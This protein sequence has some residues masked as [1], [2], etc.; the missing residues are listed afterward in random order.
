[1]KR[2]FSIILA[3]LMALTLTVSAFAEEAYLKTGFDNKFEDA[4]NWVTTFNQQESMLKI[5]DG[6][7][8]FTREW[9]DTNP[10]DPNYS[11][12]YWIG[13]LK[14]GTTY[15]ISYKAMIP[16]G[17]TELENVKLCSKITPYD[18]N[19]RSNFIYVDAVSTVDV[20]ITEGEWTTV[21]YTF[22]PEQ[23]YT[24]VAFSIS[25]TNT[26]VP[27]EQNKR[28]SP[29]YIDDVLI[30]TNAEEAV[31]VTVDPNAVP[32]PDDN[33]VYG[34][35]DMLLT[36]WTDTGSKEY[37][38]I[39]TIDKSGEYTFTIDGMDYGKTGITV[40]FIK[41]ANVD[42]G[43]ATASSFPAGT[44][45]ITKSI[46]VN[47]EEKAFTVATAEDPFV[48]TEGGVVD[49]NWYN[50]WGNI[51]LDMFDGLFDI[52]SVEVTVEFVLPE[53]GA[54]EAP[55]TTEEAPD[56]T[57]E[58]PDTNEEAPAETAEEDK[59]AETGLALAVIPAAIAMAVVVISKRR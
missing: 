15:Y 26:A 35:Q 30:T 38:E 28:I 32:D 17:A 2:L 22:T 49:V 48:L 18:G 24:D 40:F 56:T 51:G 25:F 8:E 12:G 43:A 50:I 3:V 47:G 20:K 42:V 29:L 10:S 58:T 34:K 23:D 54:E 36:L 31:P 13:D 41:D 14:S 46:K 16:E 39:L 1:M 52:N 57:E 44:K 11:V 27:V 19:D 37:S 4:V 5:V 21:S 55:D 59:P 53:E 9:S 33:L 7:L 45:V 6:T